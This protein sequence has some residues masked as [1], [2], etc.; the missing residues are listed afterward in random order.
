MP[1]AKVLIVDDDN[2][3]RT[4]IN[5][6]LRAHGYET[7]YAVDAYEAL[8]VARRE[9]P[10][11][12]VLDYGLPGGDALTVIERLHR[13]ASLAAVPIIVVSARE[14]EPN[15]GL[16]IAAG[17]ACFLEKPFDPDELLRE[18]EQALHGS[19][20]IPAD[21]DGRVFRAPDA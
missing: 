16:A 6:L 21:P 2:V 12:V 20:Q 13:V 9:Q 11:A 5:H 7:C 4:L 15:A 17:A 10:D 3:V 18:L 14:S 19:T 8:A 1:V